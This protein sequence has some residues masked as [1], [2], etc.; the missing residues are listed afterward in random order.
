[1]PQP[2]SSARP[3][4]RPARCGSSMRNRIGAHAAIPPEVFFGLADVG[5]FRRVHQAV[6]RYPCGPRTEVGHRTPMNRIANARSWS[7]AVVCG[8]LRVFVL[9]R[10]WPTGLHFRQQALVDPAGG[11][12]GRDLL[13]ARVGLPAPFLAHAHL[14]GER[15]GVFRTLL[16]DGRVARFRQF[17]RLGQFAQRFFE[18]GDGGLYVGARLPG[19]TP[20]G[21][22][23]RAPR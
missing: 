13:G 20:S 4:L 19:R 9:G 17:A 16:A 2:A 12:L 15:L 6:H 14:D 3:I 18:V 7:S 10:S 11:A 22:P 5:E 23:S 1:M 21:R 8:R